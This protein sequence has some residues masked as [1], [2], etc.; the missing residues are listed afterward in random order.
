MGILAK[1]EDP[2]EMPHIAAIHLTRSAL[3]AE[4]K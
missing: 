2:V 1:S 3:F 4:T